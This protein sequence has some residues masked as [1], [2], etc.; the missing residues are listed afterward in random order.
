MEI[1]IIGFIVM[2]MW[3]MDA[4]ID[5]NIMFFDKVRAEI[6][7]DFYLHT[8]NLFYDSYHHTYRDIKKPDFYATEK[9]VEQAKKQ[10]IS[11]P[12]S[13]KILCFLPNSFLSFTTLVVNMMCT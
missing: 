8:N 3:C 4:G 2:F 6:I 13:L 11:G 9:S 7:N 5:N 1:F 10:R 12:W